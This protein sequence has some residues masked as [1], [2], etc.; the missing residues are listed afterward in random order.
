M[1]LTPHPDLKLL[2][3]NDTITVHVKLLNKLFSLQ[4][5]RFDWLCV[6]TAFLIPPSKLSDDVTW[7]IKNFLHSVILV[8][9]C[10]SL[11]VACNLLQS[12]LYA[13][14]WCNPNEHDV[15]TAH[16]R[17]RIPRV[18]PLYVLCK[19][20]KMTFA[21]SMLKPAMISFTSSL[22]FLSGSVCH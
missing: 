17:S 10:S 7:A 12:L 2:H 15:F 11:Q 19:P 18:H 9:F 8:G 13:T 20:K 6:G 14:P 4:L 21:R 22:P 16:T 5:G 3:I 1:L